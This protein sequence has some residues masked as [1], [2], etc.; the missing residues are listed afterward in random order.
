MIYMFLAEGFEEIEAITPLDILRRAG[1]EIQ[2]VSV[3]G[4]GLDVM[5]AHGILVRADIEMKDVLAEEAEMIILPG[6]SK[7]TQGLKDS[8]A[9]REIILS[10]NEREGYIAAIC[11][12]PTVLGDMG[13]LNKRRAT[14][15]PSLAG[16]LIEKGA[17]YRT[18]KVVLDGHFITSEGAGTA[19]DFGFALTDKLFSR[20]ETDTLRLSMV[21]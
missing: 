19:A 20:S 3:N 17:K 2:T 10:V 9:L 4:N 21:Y 6:G 13:L 16:A 5:G 12:A 14:C 15:Y 1:A 11:A 7:G 18:D 8:E